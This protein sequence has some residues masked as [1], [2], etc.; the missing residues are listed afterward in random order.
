[1]ARRAS[2]ILS[3]LLL[4]GLVPHGHVSSEDS[5]RSFDVEARRYEFTPS[6]LE[7]THGDSV[8]ITIRS[9]DRKH[10][11]GIDRLGIEE[12]VARRGR[13]VTIEFVADTVGE[14]EI[15]CTEYC[16]R[17]HKRMKGVLVVKPRAETR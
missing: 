8:R 12:E 11:F 7:V 4:V 16:G 14:F 17:G 15:E 9:A 3:T 6:R 5:V 13:P 2:W 1:M 10:G